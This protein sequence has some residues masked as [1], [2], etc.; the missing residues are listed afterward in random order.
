VIQFKQLTFRN[1]LSVGNQEIT[2]DLN[3][4]K[5]TLIHGANGS[6]KSTILDALC[7]VLFNK[8]SRNINLPQLIN[9]Q[10]KKGLL[11][12]IVFSIGKNEFTVLRGMKPKVFKLFRNG[13]EIEA[14]AADRDNQTHL[15]QNILKMNYKTFIQVVILGSTNYIPFMALSAAHRRDCVEE[16]LDIKVFS[17]MAVLAKERLRGLKD[18]LRVTDGDLSNVDFKL[19]VLNERFE[20]I[21]AKSQ[22]D[23]QALKN[24]LKEISESITKKRQLIER[25]ERHY[26][27]VQ[28]LRDSVASSSP[29]DKTSEVQRV[30]A[31]LE[32]K[33]E[34]LQKDN[35]FYAK[36]DDCPTCRQGIT[37]ET[38]VKN[39]KSNDRNISSHHEG[40]HEGQKVIDKMSA[41]LRILNNRDNHLRA[42]QL[43]LNTYKTDLQ[44]LE[45]QGS[46][47]ANKLK[48]IEN[49]K[50]AMDK[51]IGKQELLNEDKVRLTHRRDELRDEVKNHEVVAGLLKDGGIKAQIVKKYLPVMNKFIRHYLT[52]LDLPLH[53][54]LDEE[55]KETVASPLHQNFS[56]AS[57][58]E[59]QKARIDLSLMFTWREIGKLK[60]SVST[61]ILFLDEV[62][63]SS[64]DETGKELLLSIL[65]YQLDDSTRVFV[66]DHTLSGEFKQKFDRTIEVT[67]IKGFS[68]YT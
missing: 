14:K 36:N 37:E 3:N 23:T 16:F 33:I 26:H 52:Q 56:Y 18:T 29:Q 32:S 20:E 50:G 1:F 48:E 2:V 21:K 43:S 53:F 41:K 8:P 27:N 67:R 61:N 46:R 4:T 57:F 64:L 49:D 59:G 54:I 5:T 31:K 62:F 28:E 63:S 9:T 17:A 30:I 40:I 60:N 47:V 68:Q 44:N 15:E 25:V 7:Y 6:G 39:I 13:E 65:R 34:R 45:I 58:S 10:N 55:F 66:V 38:K 12:E 35:Q 24:E 22:A 11:V 19:E 42:L 51:E